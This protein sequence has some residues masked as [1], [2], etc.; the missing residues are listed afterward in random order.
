[1]KFNKYVVS[2]H[3]EYRFISNRECI[4]YELLLFYANYIFD[5][6]LEISMIIYCWLIVKKG[7]KKLLNSSFCYASGIFGIKHC[8]KLVDYLVN[9]LSIIDV[10]IKR[11]IETFLFF[12]YLLFIFISDDDILYLIKPSFFRSLYSYEFL[13]FFKTFNVWMR[14]NVL[15]WVYIWLIFLY[16]HNIKTIVLVKHINWWI[17]FLNSFDIFSMCSFVI[18]IFDPL[19]KQQQKFV[20]GLSILSRGTLEEKLCWTFQ[21]YDINGDGRITKEEMN[22]IVTAIYNLMGHPTEEKI[23]ENRIKAKVER[24]F[25]V[26]NFL[27]FYV[28][29]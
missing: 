29:I 5:V 17:I 24:I 14:I 15:I 13:C 22:D 23:D 3:N 28:V 16:F 26:S 1:M 19:I 12:Y 9:P 11:P 21:L 20:Q 2:T 8:S 10:R 27:F 7:K 25:N 6:L 4:S 18:F